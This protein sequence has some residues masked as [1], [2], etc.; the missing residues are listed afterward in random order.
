[1]SVYE[2]CND[3][4]TNRNLAKTDIAEWQNDIWTSVPKEC[5]QHRNVQDLYSENNSLL[6]AKL[7]E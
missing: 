7:K 2:S 4:N 3:T 5:F 1:M 6:T